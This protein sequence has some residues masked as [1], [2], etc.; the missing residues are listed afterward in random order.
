MFPHKSEFMTISASSNIFKHN[1]EA[2]NSYPLIQVVQ[3]RVSSLLT[4]ERE[5]FSHENG[6]AAQPFLDE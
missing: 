2:I 4:S 3:N 5:Q 6:H 1:P